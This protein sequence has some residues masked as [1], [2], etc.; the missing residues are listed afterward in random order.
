MTALEIIL[1]LNMAFNAAVLF[2]IW[3]HGAKQILSRKT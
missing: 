1:W 2:S 3:L